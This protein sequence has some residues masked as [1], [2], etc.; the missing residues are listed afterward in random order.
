MKASVIRVPLPRE[1]TQ[2]PDRDEQEPD[3]SECTAAEATPAEQWNRAAHANVA[4]MTFGLSPVSL[5]LALLDW[6]AHLAVSPGKC[7]ELAT[8]A[9]LA[10]APAAAEK[11]AAD[12][13]D[14]DGLAVHAGH[15]DPRFAAIGD[16][17][18]ANTNVGV[19]LLTVESAEAR[20]MLGRIQNEL[21]D[22]GADLATPAGIEGALRIQP[23]Q[24]GR[25]ERAIH[26]AKAEATLATQGLAGEI[27]RAK[28]ERAFWIL[29]KK[30]ADN[31]PARSVRL[32]RR[33]QRSER[34]E[35]DA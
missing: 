9:W 17:D 23:G 31:T 10:A 29:Q 7:F 11:G 35:A 20:A 21:F 14:T 25:L 34:T 18:E 30:F 12:D 28:E 4:A 26:A 15:A 1:S 13:A 24:I 3:R 33:R 6:G 16:V 27:E 22:L 8:Q 19:A 32:Q 5:A 2:S